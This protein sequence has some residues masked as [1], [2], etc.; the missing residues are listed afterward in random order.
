MWSGCRSAKG[1]DLSTACL[2]CI[3][4]YPRGFSFARGRLPTSGIVLPGGC[5]LLRGGN[6]LVHWVHILLPWWHILIR[7]DRVVLLWG[8]IP[9]HGPW[10][11][12]SAECGTYSAAWGDIVL[13]VIPRGSTKFSEAGTKYL[14]LGSQCLAPVTRHLVLY[15]NYCNT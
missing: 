8:S 15:T 7:G 3:K 10:G 13:H 14:V 12:Y 6:L 5:T 1:M 4:N 9:L 11:Q 2:K